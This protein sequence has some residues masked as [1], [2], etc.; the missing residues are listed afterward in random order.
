MIVIEEYIDDQENVTLTETLIF[1]VVMVMVWGGISFADTYG[2]DCHSW[3]LTPD[4]DQ[5]NPGI[6]CCTR[7]SIYWERVSFM[8]DNVRPH[9]V[10]ES[11]LTI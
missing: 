6:S 11:T 7:C 9:T 2:T 5:G 8:Y 4:R 1:D 10:S 3:I